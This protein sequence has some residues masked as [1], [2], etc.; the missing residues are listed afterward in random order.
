MTNPVHH[1][2]SESKD[3]QHVLQLVVND[4]SKVYRLAT[5]NKDKAHGELVTAEQMEKLVSD[6]QEK[7]YEGMDIHG[8]YVECTQY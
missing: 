4:Y 2:I 5:F 8:R 6:I 7:G 3:G 1:Y